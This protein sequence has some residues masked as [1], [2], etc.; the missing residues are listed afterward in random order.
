M[1]SDG[2]AGAICANGSV[3]TLA[4]CWAEWRARVQCRAGSARYAIH[5]AAE[6]R[7]CSGA[8]KH[9]ENNSQGGVWWEASYQTAGVGGGGRGRCSVV[10]GGWCW[11]LLEVR[12]ARSVGLLL[13][14]GERAR[15]GE[16]EAQTLDRL[17]GSQSGRYTEQRAS[18]GEGQ[19]LVGTINQC[20]NLRRAPSVTT[21]SVIRDSCGMYSIHGSGAAATGR[22]NDSGSENG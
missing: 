13:A 10:Q 21:W 5:S 3:E 19:P 6:M 17:R 1:G 20:T 11:R 12:G 9:K 15:E 2:R 16:R 4:G 8:D 22:S 7:R 14:A 18:R